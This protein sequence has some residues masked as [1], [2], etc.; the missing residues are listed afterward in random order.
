MIKETP[1]ILKY[2]FAYFTVKYWYKEYK[3]YNKNCN[4]NYNNINKMQQ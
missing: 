1:F 3:N 4:K 2:C